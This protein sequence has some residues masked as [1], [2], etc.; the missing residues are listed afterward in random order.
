MMLEK[1]TSFM[2]NVPK[3]VGIQAAKTQVPEVSMQ[4]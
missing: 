2:Q 4:F 1:E 3:L